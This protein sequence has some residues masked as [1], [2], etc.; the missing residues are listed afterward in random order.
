MAG[1]EF[2]GKSLDALYAMVVAAKPG[3]LTSAG[4]ALA[5]AA[6]KILGIAQDLRSH[7]ARVAWEGEGGEAFRNWGRGVVSETMM[8]GDF[9]MVVG[10]EMQRAGQALTEAKAAVPKPAGM[11]FADPEKE[12]ARLESE[13]GPKLQEAVN[14]MNRLS[15]YYGASRDRI[16]A[17]P[18]PVF[19]PMPGGGRVGESERRYGSDVSGGTGETASYGSQTGSSGGTARGHVAPASVTGTGG[20]GIVQSPDPAKSHVPPETPVSTG[21]DSATVAPPRENTTVPGTLGPLSPTSNGGG[22]GITPPLVPPVSPVGSVPIGQTGGGTRTVAPA[23]PGALRGSA[24]AGPFGAPRVGAAEG[25]V[26]GR[27]VPARGGGASSNG[28]RLPMGTVVGEERGALGGRGAAG[29]PG[30]ASGMH[31]A[32]GAGGVQG[33]RRL[34]TQPGGAVGLPRTSAVAARGEFTPGGTGL[35]RPPFSTGTGSDERRSTAAR[36]DYLGEDEETWA[37]G[38]RHI[39]PPVI[40]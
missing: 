29:M 15:S 28:P 2:E 17:E 12:K 40:D 33:G 27:P 9:T 34:A 24:P 31:G 36:P 5:K 8:L 11:C 32:P 14:Q 30:H 38:Q 26:G 3:E 39:V 13:T 1:S 23:M 25:I 22:G 37:V 21:L 10:E 19:E 6:P 7:L 4:E 16:A 20:Q 35:V 18:E